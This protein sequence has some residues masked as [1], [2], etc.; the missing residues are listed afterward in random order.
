[1]YSV[2]SFFLFHSILVIFL[3]Y[4][5]FVRYPVNPEY[6]YYIIE[7]YKQTITMQTYC[8]SERSVSRA[9]AIRAVDISLSLPLSLALYLFL[10]VYIIIKNTR[11]VR[12]VH[13]CSVLMESHSAGRY[14]K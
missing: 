11:T 13:V 4:F 12:T 5:F 1:M 10:N 8:S 3:F 2:V 9:L 7:H 6:L 14:F